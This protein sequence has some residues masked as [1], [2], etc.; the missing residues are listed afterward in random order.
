MPNGTLRVYA[1][2]AG[3]AAPLAGVRLAVQGEI[4]HRAGPAW[5]PDAAGAA[6]PLSL[7]APGY[8]LQSGRRATGRCAPMPS[9]G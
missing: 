2:V 3:Q 9:T 8:P 6:G 1:S 4:R 7:E 5:K